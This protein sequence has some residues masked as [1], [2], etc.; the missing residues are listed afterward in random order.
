MKPIF[1]AAVAAVLLLTVAAAA[2]P[3]ANAYGNTVTQILPDGTKMITYINADMTWEQ[4]IGDHAM[5]GTYAWKDATHAC[6][7]LVDPVPADPA[8]ATSCSEIKG[9]HKVGDTWTETMPDGKT[10]TISLTAGR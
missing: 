3:F 6:F 10:I 9:D 1:P 7:T 2:D 8:K 5:K 4:H